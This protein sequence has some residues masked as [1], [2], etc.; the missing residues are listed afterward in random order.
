MNVVE[1][2]RFCT[3]R[4]SFTPQKGF[5]HKGFFFFSIAPKGTVQNLETFLMKTGEFGGATGP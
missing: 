4:S 3:S 2:I 1:T 5:L